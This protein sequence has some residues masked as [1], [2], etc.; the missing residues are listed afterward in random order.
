MTAPIKIPRLNPIRFVSAYRQNLLFTKS[1]ASFE[2]PVSFLQIFNRYDTL[3]FQIAVKRGLNV[4]FAACIMDVDGNEKLPIQS[5]GLSISGGDMDYFEFKTILSSLP[6]GQYFVQVEIEFN[7]STKSIL[8]ISEP[9]QVKNLHTDSVL[10][11]YTHDQNDFDILF[12][13]EGKSPRAYSL[14]I[15]GGFASDGFLP[16][17][18][19]TVY[20]NQEFDTVLLNSTPYSTHKLTL[21]HAAGIPNWLIDKVNRILSC[22]CVKI[23]GVQWVKNEGAKLEATREKNYPMAGWSIELIKANHDYSEAFGLGDYNTDY[24]QDYLIQN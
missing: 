23:D 16:F 6:E 24:N 18:K 2:E 14:R 15:Q 8:L 7:G 17:A 5:T 10:L 1:I 9:F 12:I 11:E 22:T 4:D 20:K 21:G 19:D 3:A 13:P